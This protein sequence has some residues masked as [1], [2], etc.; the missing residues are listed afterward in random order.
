MRFLRELRA[1]RVLL[2]DVEQRGAR[3][4]DADNLLRVDRRHLAELYEVL[5]FA[6][7]VR[8]DVAHDDGSHGRRD[9]RGQ[10]RAGDALDATHHQRACG[11]A[12]TG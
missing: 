7:G 2:A 1:L 6:V 8:P 3:M 12:G 4:L 9:D 10:R 11:Q 5:G